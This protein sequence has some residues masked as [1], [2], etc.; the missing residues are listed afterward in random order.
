MGEGGGGSC[1]DSVGD[2]QKRKMTSSHDL[3]ASPFPRTKCSNTILKNSQNSRVDG[4]IIGR[5]SLEN[6]FCL[7]VANSV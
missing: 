6:F 1:I 5:M 2:L 4:S 7:N 3:Q